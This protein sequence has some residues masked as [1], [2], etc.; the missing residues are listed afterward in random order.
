[1]VT[2]LLASLVEV[3]VVVVVVVVVVVPFSSVVDVD[4]STVLLAL[5]EQPQVPNA[6]S[7]K[8]DILVDIHYPHRR[9]EKK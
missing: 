3:S 8:A 2:S 9:K 1:M 4:V 5:N 7:W 6:G